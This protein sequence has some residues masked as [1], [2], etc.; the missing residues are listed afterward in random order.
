MK[1]RIWVTLSLSLYNSYILLSVYCLSS[2]LY[3]LFAIIYRL[4]SMIPGRAEAEWWG[5]YG[6][7]YLCHCT[8]LK[9]Y[10]FS[11][12]VYHRLSFEYCLHPLSIILRKNV[13]LLFFSLLDYAS[14]C[15]CLPSLWG[16]VTVRKWFTL[17]LSLYNS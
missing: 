9:S 17:S 16:W 1:M 14:R 6:L 12:I 5:R 8:M 15:A 10:S 3:Q 2:I 4:S 13:L 11:S 7:L